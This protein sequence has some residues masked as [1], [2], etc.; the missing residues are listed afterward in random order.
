MDNFTEDYMEFL[1]EVM[2]YMEINGYNENDIFSISISFVD[3]P[4]AKLVNKNYL[5]IFTY[6]RIIINDILEND[7][8]EIIKILITFNDNTRVSFTF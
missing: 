1:N 4:I 5:Y 7:I 2:E 8:N 3:E 6:M